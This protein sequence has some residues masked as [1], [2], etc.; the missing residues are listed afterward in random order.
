MV[1]FWSNAQV[2]LTIRLRDESEDERPAGRRNSMID[3]LECPAFPRSNA[4]TKNLV[5]EQRRLVRRTD[6]H[7]PEGRLETRRGLGER[8]TAR[9]A[10]AVSTMKINRYGG[11]EDGRCGLLGRA[12]Q[13]QRRPNGRHLVAK[14]TDRAVRGALELDAL[15]VVRRRGV[16][17]RAADQVTGVLGPGAD[18]AR[19]LVRT[20]RGEQRR[21]QHDTKH[22]RR[23]TGGSDHERSLEFPATS[24][25]PGAHRLLHLPAALRHPCPRS[26]RLR[27]P[28]P[29]GSQRTTRTPVSWDRDH[30]RRR[31]GSSSPDSR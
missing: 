30:P 24:V 9:T 29:R 4:G 22:P 14:R 28:C 6:R 10:R 5:H 13:H 8:R 12:Q 3:P 2:A 15:H 20:A 18:G 7:T 23:D 26:A 17:G 27:C 25:N 31:Q 19:V 16:A 1:A 21:D 11:R